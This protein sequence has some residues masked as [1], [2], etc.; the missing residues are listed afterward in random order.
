MEDA[1]HVAAGLMQLPR[2][3]LTNC[4]S[5]HKTVKFSIALCTYNGA[6]YLPA[7]LDSIAAQTL[8]PD[9]LVICDDCSTDETRDVITSFAARAP[10]AVRL[11]VNEVNLGSTKNFEQAISLCTGDII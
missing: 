10:F 4:T 5:K 7:Q 3:P 1:A 11:Y 2:P 9:E 8:L 6:R